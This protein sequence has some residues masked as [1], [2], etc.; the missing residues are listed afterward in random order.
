M[1]LPPSTPKLNSLWMG[2]DWGVYR[3]LQ[4]AARFRESCRVE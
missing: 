3:L 2:W 4:V 1:S